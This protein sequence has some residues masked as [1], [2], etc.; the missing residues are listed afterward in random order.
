MKIYPK[1][2]AC[3][4]PVKGYKQSFIYDLQ[5]P[6]SSNAIPNDLYNILILHEN[7]TI[8][9]IKKEF[10]NQYDEIIDD[11]FDF[12]DRNEFIYN[13]YEQELGCFP[14][15]ENIWETPSC[16]TNSI[17]HIDDYNE[18]ILKK[19]VSELSILRCDALQLCF[20]KTPSFNLLSET[21]SLFENTRILSVEI[22]FNY[23]AETLSQKDILDIL[24][25]NPRFQLLFIGNIYLDFSTTNRKISYSTNKI[26][27]ITDCGKISLLDFT[28]NMNSFFEAK[29]YNSCLNRKLCIDAEGNIKNC[30][31]MK[32]NFGNIKDITLQEAIEKPGFKDLWFICKDQIDV[33]KDCEFR[34]MCTDCRCFIKD[35]ENIYSQPAKC[36]YNSYICKWQGQKGYVPVEECGTYSKEAGFVPDET[37]ITELNKQIWKD[38]A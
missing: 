30:P 33:C 3:C 18:N 36:T 7:K 22:L 10:N 6:K 31:S 35:S 29:N 5:R 19:I 21:A 13:F 1:L 11:Y 20:L 38:D 15:L 28:I 25:F 16:V 4:I 9:E 23:D 14:P 37:K 32:Q 8:E 12:L 17:V 27:F 26:N 34:Y 24:K 2:Y